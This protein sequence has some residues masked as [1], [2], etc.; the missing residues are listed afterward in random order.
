MLRMSPAAVPW[1]VFFFFLSSFSRLS[2]EV[3]ETTQNRVFFLNINM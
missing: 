2:L 3:P 1:G